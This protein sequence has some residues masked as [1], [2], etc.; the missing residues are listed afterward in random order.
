MHL[1]EKEKKYVIDVIETFVTSLIVFV[2]IYGGIIFPEIVLGASMEPTLYTGERIFVE[3]LSKHVSDFSRGDIVVLHPP[4]DDNEDYVKRVVGLP[5][6]VIKIVNCHVYIS[7]DGN[8]FILSEPYLS[9]GTCTIDG[10]KLKEG[11]A[12]RIPDNMYVVLGD[13]RQNSRDSRSFGF[14][15]KGRILGKVVFR[16]W[17]PSR[18]GFINTNSV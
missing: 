2:I 3:K 9:G 8:K 13:N 16:F 4:G 10:P 18:F 5:G 14:V 1:N 7:T 6:D 17:P 12:Q 15:D 11:V